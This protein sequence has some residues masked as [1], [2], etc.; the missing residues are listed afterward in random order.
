M[1]DSRMSGINWSRVLLGGV[2]AGIILNAGR[3]LVNGVLLREK[4][5]DALKGWPGDV[6]SSIQ[7]AVVG[8]LAGIFTVWLYAAIRP[9]YGAGPKTAVL[10]GGAVWVLGYLLAWGTPMSMHLLPADLVL[11]SIAAGLVNVIVAALA[12]AWLYTEPT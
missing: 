4:W 11:T 5:A 7:I 12:G 10:A 6:T 3:Y 1:E 9:R 2:I 8:F